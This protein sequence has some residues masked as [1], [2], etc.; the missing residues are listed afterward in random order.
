VAASK[1]EI[2][3]FA[4]TG[5]SAHEQEA[6]LCDFKH[7]KLEPPRVPRLIYGDATPKP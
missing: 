4:K 3:Q 1:G 2:R 5:K 6:A 7:D